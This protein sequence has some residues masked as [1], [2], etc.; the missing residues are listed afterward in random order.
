MMTAVTGPSRV[1]ISP[2]CMNVMNGKKVKHH[3]RS[4]SFP[5]KHTHTQIFL[6]RLY[7]VFSELQKVKHPAAYSLFFFFFSM[8][9]TSQLR[10][11][12]SELDLVS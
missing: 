6:F 1:L 8:Y 3:F 4:E 12:G 2:P 10:R 11:S 7:R 9:R 5:Y